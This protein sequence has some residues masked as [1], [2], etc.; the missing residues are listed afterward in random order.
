[1]SQGGKPIP[2]V[3]VMGAGPVD[4]LTIRANLESIEILFRLRLQPMEYGFLGHGP[5]RCVAL[6]AA[7]KRPE[8]G[9]QAKVVKKRSQLF[10]RFFATNKVSIRYL[11]MFEECAVLGDHNAVLM[12]REGGKLRV[13]L[14]IGRSRI[15]SQH[16][17]E[18]SQLSHIGVHQKS[19]AG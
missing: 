14:I 13:I 9:G 12:K 5:K 8:W 7:G 4:A 6:Q 19:Q 11:A 18:P 1:M 16:T 17:D 3:L 15:K 2:H 10:L